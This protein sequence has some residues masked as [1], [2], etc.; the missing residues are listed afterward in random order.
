MDASTMNA[1]NGQSRLR[2]SVITRLIAALA[3]TVPVLGG[4]LSSL[5]LMRVFSAMR[6]TE[7]AGV[8]AVMRGMK[9]ASLPV[10]VS[11]Y[12]AAV[13]GIVV[14]I[15]I[16]VRMIVVTKT[17]S[18][19]FWFFAVGGLLCLIPAGLFWKAELL[20]I[21]VLSPGGSIGSA[22]IG[23]VAADLSRSLLTSIIAAPVAFIVLVVL[24]VLPLKS[25]IRTKWGSLAITT[26]ITVMFIATAIAVP[27][28]IDGPTRKNEMVNLPVNIKNA[29]RNYDAEKDTSMLI[30]LTADNKLYQ[31]QTRDLP[32]R[33]ERTET[34][35]TK[36]ELH[37]KIE[38][39]LEGKTPEQRVVYFRCDVNASYDN[40]LQL[41]GDIP[42]PG[43]K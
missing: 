28:L 14:I 43:V 9:E 36:E 4:A 16:V 21:E 40:G 19:P 33:T 17:S 15:V 37:A 29:D 20:V 23:S 39:T 2:V 6:T 3:Y 1:D 13:L 38:G 25:S 10:Y 22:G 32:D 42:N 26:L 34:V 24:S 5:F 18:P 30:T 35:I 7:N 31:R 12:L 27:F 11:L 41:F 8:T